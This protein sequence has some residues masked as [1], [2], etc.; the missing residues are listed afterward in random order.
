MARSLPGLLGRLAID[1][2]G[3]ADPI[4]RAVAYL[5]ICMILATQWDEP[6]FCVFAVDDRWCNGRLCS[7]RLI[8][9]S[10]RPRLD[11]HVDGIASSASSAEAEKAAIA[12][13]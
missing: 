11:C 13:R 2:V 10:H 5:S 6:S 3:V 9:S 12:F 4:H 1:V 7:A 8:W